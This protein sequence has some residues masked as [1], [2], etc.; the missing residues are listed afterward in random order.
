MNVLLANVVLEVRG[1]IDRLKWL[2][3]PRGV[4]SMKS[5]YEIILNE[6]IHLCQK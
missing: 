3:D 6:G 5:T 1:T 2:A 4:Y